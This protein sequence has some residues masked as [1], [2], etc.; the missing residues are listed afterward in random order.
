MRERTDN[1]P[2]ALRFHLHPGDDL[3]QRGVLVEPVTEEKRRH[4]LAVTLDSLLE[5]VAPL[6]FTCSGCTVAIQSEQLALVT[7]WRRAGCASL[8][9]VVKEVR[10][11]PAGGVGAGPLICV[12]YH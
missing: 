8:L 4:C 9:S 3:K 10:W 12:T 5:D 11:W 1:P 2:G 6:V 7:E